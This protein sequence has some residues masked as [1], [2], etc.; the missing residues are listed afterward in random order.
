MS[1]TFDIIQEEDFLKPVEYILS[2][3]KDQHIILLNGN[4]GAGKTTFSK[5][6]C[7][8]LGIPKHGVS[9]PTFSIV[10]THKTD[11]TTV[12]H[13]D[14]Y[15]IKSTEEL[16]DIGFEDYLYS[17]HFCLIEWPDIGLSLVPQNHIQIQIQVLENKRILTLNSR[18]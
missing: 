7:E 10:N 15:R 14:L 9:S 4:L 8:K 1:I 13:F 18:N 17:Q 16:L 5:Y 6:F 12:H 3:L 2:E 11:K